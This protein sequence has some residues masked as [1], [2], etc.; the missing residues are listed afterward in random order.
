MGRRR[1]TGPV[2]ARGLPAEPDE[3]GPAAQV[4]QVG[5]GTS[6]RQVARDL[7]GLAHL[8]RDENNARRNRTPRSARRYLDNAVAAGSRGHGPGAAEACRALA[9]RIAEAFVRPG[10]PTADDPWPPEREHALANRLLGSMHHV[11]MDLVDRSGE[12]AEHPLVVVSCD[13]Y[14]RV[15]QAL[16]RDGLGEGGL[17]QVVGGV[18]PPMLHAMGMREPR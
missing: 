17:R 1:S 2:V 12:R 18:T 7:R 15:V 9:T 5:P 3:A 11:A 4:G 6:A 14:R 10:E 13:F 16:E 8:L